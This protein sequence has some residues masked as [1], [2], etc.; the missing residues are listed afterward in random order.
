MRLG[1]T[2]GMTSGGDNTRD[3]IGWGQHQGWHLGDYLLGMT[4]QGWPLGDDMENDLLGMP[5][6]RWPFGDDLLGMAFWGLHLRDEIW[7]TLG[8]DDI[9]EDLRDNIRDDIRQRWD[10]GQPWGWYLGDYL[11]G[12]T[13]QGWPLGNDMENDLFGDAISEM[14]FWRWPFKDDLLGITSQGWHLDNIGWGWHQGF[15]L[16]GDDIQDDLG[17][18]IR[19]GQH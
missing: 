11:L 3:D 6:Q 12:M 16:G 10:W 2:L 18:N 1:T 4:S 17:D 7:T 13:S 15:T 5:S 9:R 8:G 19:W 14:T